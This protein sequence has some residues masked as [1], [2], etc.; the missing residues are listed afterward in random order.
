MTAKNRIDALVSAFALLAATALLLV[1][2]SA[3]GIWDPWELDV[4]E[5]AR[6]GNLSSPPLRDLLLQASLRGL[7]VS[8][9]SG[10]LPTAMG[11]LLVVLFVFLLG[12]RSGGSRVGAYGALVAA[13]TPLLL[14][15][16]RTL[17]GHAIP[18]AAQAGLGLALYSAVF[19]GRTDAD[20][21][22]TSA[23]GPRRTTFVTAGWLVLASGFTLASIA[24]A[25]LLVGV[26]P[27]LLAVSVLALLDGRPSL[28]S[29][30]ARDVSASVAILASVVAASGVGL[31]IYGDAAGYSAITGGSASGRETGSF[32]ALLETVL[33]GFAPWSALLL[34]GLAHAIE[35]RVEAEGPGAASTLEGARHRLSLFGVL[36]AA[37]GYAAAALYDARYGSG[38]FLPVAALA[39]VIAAFLVSVEE[40]EEGFRM[41]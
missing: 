32:E 2:L 31:A 21:P 22:F 16:A 4:I 26:L 29:R 36:W 9:W 8:E 34:L 20:A 6:A 13:T 25:G 5:L 1:G 12:R 38:A 39:I 33:H 14:F 15:N 19:P 11:G 7:G 18:M 10:R 30:D 17:I 37:G 24:S 28:G 35:P 41:G 3:Y 23:T 40:S 27:P